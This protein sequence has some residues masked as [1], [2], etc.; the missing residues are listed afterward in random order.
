MQALR[1]SLSR[2]MMA[3][4]ERYPSPTMAAELTEKTLISPLLS[5]LRAKSR[6]LMTYIGYTLWASEARLWQASKP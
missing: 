6:M 5:T 2:Y 3:A 4:K 1:I